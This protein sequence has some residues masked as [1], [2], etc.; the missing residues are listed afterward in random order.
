MPA[1]WQV[2]RSAHLHRRRRA[3]VLLNAFTQQRHLW[4]RQFHRDWRFQC[5]PILQVHQRDITLAHLQAD[6][7]PR[8]VHLQLIEILHA[9]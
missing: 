6:R 1:H 3:S 8:G 2:V 7:R 4:A 5:A 9:L